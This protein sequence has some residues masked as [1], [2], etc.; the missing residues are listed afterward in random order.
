MTSAEQTLPARYWIC[1]NHGTAVTRLIF[2]IEKLNGEIFLLGRCEIDTFIFG[3]SSVILQELKVVFQSNLI[4]VRLFDQ[5]F[6]SL[7]FPLTKVLSEE[8]KLPG[9]E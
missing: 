9:N 2:V 5:Y 6:I 7:N 3:S 8:R 1:A 4:E